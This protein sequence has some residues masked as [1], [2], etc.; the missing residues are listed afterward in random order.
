[1][2]SCAHLHSTLTE[3]FQPN[4][5]SNECTGINMRMTAITR[6]HDTHTPALAHN[7][8][9]LWVIASQMESSEFRWNTAGHW[10]P[11][12]IFV[13][14]EAPNS[15]NN[16]PLLW[17]IIW[18]FGDVNQPASTVPSANKKSEQKHAFIIQ[19]GNMKG[20]HFGSMSCCFVTLTLL[21]Q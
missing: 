15:T 9:S 17:M 8:N 2:P 6:R 7:T 4:G 5:L 19:S 10:M 3:L 13:Y 18:N 14:I 1:M 16:P 11:Y 21:Y 20:I 12:Y